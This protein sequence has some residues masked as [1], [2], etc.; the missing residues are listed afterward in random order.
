MTSADSRMEDAWK[1]QTPEL[2]RDIVDN[3][4]EMLAQDCV[5][6]MSE[7]QRLLLLMKMEDDLTYEEIGLR[8]NESSPSKLQYHFKKSLEAIRH[9]WSLWGPPSLKQ[10]ADVDE[11][12]FY[13]FYEKVISICKNGQAFRSNKED[14]QP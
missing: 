9:K 2:D 1:R 13:L 5:T 12:E 11:E 3:E 4:L 10:F 14:I 7:R 8:L 6:G